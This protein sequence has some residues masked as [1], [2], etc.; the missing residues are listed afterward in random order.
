MILRVISEEEDR[1]NKTIDNGLAILQGLKED[2][3]KKGEKL[4]SGE[5]AFR[6]YDTYGFPLDLTKEILEDS[7]ITVDEEAFQEAM[8]VQRETARAARKSTNYMGRDDVYQNLDA[9]L[10]TEFVGY[11]TLE[12]EG[13]ITACLLYTSG[14]IPFPAYHY[15]MCCS[16]RKLCENHTKNF[17]I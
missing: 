3:Q 17:P 16:R 15:C 10:K 2:L 6:L 4:L 5:D 14:S 11:E 8:K 9:S 7:G 1:F 12:C 13:K